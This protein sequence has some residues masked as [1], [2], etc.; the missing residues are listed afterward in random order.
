M[1]VTATAPSPRTLTGLR[2]I[3]V[4]RAVFALIWALALVVA[5]PERGLALT[6]L[7]VLYPVVDACA[8][9]A[10][11]RLSGRA[12]SG[13]SE[14]IN[15][16]VS[17]AVAVAVGVA[18]WVSVAAAV[19]VWGAWAVLSGGTQ[20]VTA[21]QHRH[22]GG[23]TPQVISGA[24]SVLAGVSFIVQ[25]T[26]GTDSISGVGGYAFLGGLF[27]LVSAVR[28]TVILRRTTPAKS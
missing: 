10:Q 25:A 11:I 15:I 9:V 4:T 17:V 24:I 12:S 28:M 18:S 26:N 14:T 7:L 6:A 20:L 5:M 1:T 21:L 8:V 23:Q 27:F 16:A 3:Y 22:I 2:G 19:G 13:V